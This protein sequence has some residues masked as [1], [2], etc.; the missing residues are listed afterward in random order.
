MTYSEDWPGTERYGDL[1]T[2][3]EAALQ[4]VLALRQI[5]DGRGPE[6]T[7]K[8]RWKQV[9]NKCAGLV[10][11]SGG[12]GAPEVRKERRKSGRNT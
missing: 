6:K 5:G 3:K 8:R 7:L 10:E 1:T 12:A 2:D 4:G 11:F 9:E